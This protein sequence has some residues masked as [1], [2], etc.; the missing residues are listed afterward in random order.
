MTVVNP[1]D[2]P[3]SVRNRCVIEIFGINVMFLCIMYCNYKK[4]F[5]FKLLSPP[6]I[7]LF[8]FHEVVFVKY[9]FKIKIERLSL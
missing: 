4:K 8:P 9:E 7:Q 5:F 3:K 2:R 1:A 6:V